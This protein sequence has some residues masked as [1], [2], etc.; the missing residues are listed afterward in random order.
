MKRFAI[1][2]QDEQ[3]EYKYYQIYDANGN[4]I[5]D[6]DISHT[7]YAD[8]EDILRLCCR[9]ALSAYYEGK[10]KGQKALRKQIRELLG[11]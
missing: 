11:V 10:N 9:C 6:V 7:N 1:T 4:V 2:Y 8:N 5:C 3:Y